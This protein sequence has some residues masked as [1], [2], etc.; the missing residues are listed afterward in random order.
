MATEI[1]FRPLLIEPD[2]QEL[3]RGCNVSP[4]PARAVA[5][6]RIELSRINA[7]NAVLEAGFFAEQLRQTDGMPLANARP[8]FSTVR[9]T[10][11]RG[12]KQPMSMTC[13]GHE[14]WYCNVYLIALTLRAL[15]AVDRYGCTR[16][17]EQYRGWD[18]LPGGVA[19]Q[20]PFVNPVD[21]ADYLLRQSGGSNPGQEAM[22]LVLTD[23]AVLASVFRAAAMR[24]HP[25]R[26]GSADVMRKCT[27]A[28]DY[29]LKHRG[30]GK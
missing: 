15:R 20:E 11:L 8:R 10:F 22:R 30:G 3:G 25:D 5:E 1:T 19:E 6:L 17:G 28:R 9:V 21:A 27:E 12:G 26:G 24:H 29:I 2:W 7:T 4:T 18:A 13:G 16:A 23:D 14:H